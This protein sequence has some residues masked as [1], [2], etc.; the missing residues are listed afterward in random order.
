MRGGGLFPTVSLLKVHIYTPGPC[1]YRVHT[2]PAVTLLGM[3]T[4]GC[5]YKGVYGRHIQGWWVHPGY[6]RVEV[7]PCSSPRVRYTP[8]LAPRVGYTPVL[9]LPRVGYTS[10]LASLGWVYPCSSL[11]RVV[12]PCSSLSGWVIPLF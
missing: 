9:A 2:L 8:V 6:G 7:Y 3:Y 11:P 1:T 10:V 4:A 5:T 12:I